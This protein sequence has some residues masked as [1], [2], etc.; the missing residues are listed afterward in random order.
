[1]FETGLRLTSGSRLVL[2]SPLP[3]VLVLFL[4]VASRLV[5]LPRSFTPLPSDMTRSPNYGT[6]RYDCEVGND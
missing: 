1:M 2:R 4:Q 3:P 6:S 5:R